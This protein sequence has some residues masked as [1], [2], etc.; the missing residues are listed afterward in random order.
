MKLDDQVDMVELK[1]YRKIDLD[2]T[3]VLA[4][5]CGHFFTA[6]TLDGLIGLNQV[7]KIDPA[8]GNILGL[9]DISSELSPAIPKCPHC[10]RPIRQYATQRYNRLINRAVI[11]EMSK[12]F[13]VTGQT[14]LQ[15]IKAG[16]E[17]LEADLENSAT[18]ASSTHQADGRPKAL[19]NLTFAAKLKT[20]YTASA[21]IR[22]A[23][24]KLQSRVNKRHEPAYKLEDAITHAKGRKASLQNM[25]EGLNLEPPAAPGERNQRISLEAKLLEFKFDCIVMEDKFKLLQSEKSTNDDSA[26]NLLSTLFQRFLESCADFFVK[27]KESALPRIAV[28]VSV[29]YS[30]VAYVFERLGQTKPSDRETATAFRERAK[31]ILSAAAGLCKQE[32]QGADVLSEAVNH[33]RE[34]LQREWYEEVSKEELKAIKKA[35]VSGSGG[36]SSHSGHWYNCANGHP[37]SL[38]SCVSMIDRSHANDN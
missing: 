17:M 14:E 18:G 4:L 5:A 24:V 9:E 33:M 35:M 15:D 21:Q 36:I 29:C 28:E 20:R 38:I 31:E 16:L 6:E 3:P 32:F 2:E 10:Q 13:L 34:L 23:I 26:V 12:R 1:E 11:D 25:L 22:S 30:R 37:V 19:K 8:T 27:C 7:Y